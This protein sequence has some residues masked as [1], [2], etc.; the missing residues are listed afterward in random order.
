MGSFNIVNNPSL[1][2]VN[3]KNGNIE[4]DY[5]I[6]Y[7]N[8]NLRYVCVDD[9]EISNIES[10]LEAGGQLNVNLNTYCTFVPG[11]ENYIIKGE[12]RVDLNNNGCDSSDTTTNLKFY[13]SDGLT[14]GT[15]IS[16]TEKFLINVPSGNYTITPKF[17]KPDYFNVL[18][19]FCKLNF[20][21][22][23]VRLFKISV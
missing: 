14:N 20:L 21:L 3:L 8:N 22:H 10:F 12:G 18:P 5:S 6:I 13:I 11:G 7:D 19:S 17:E 2:I 9:E 1:E 15:I 23:Q 16:N 4:K